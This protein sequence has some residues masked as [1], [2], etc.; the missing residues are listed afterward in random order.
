M[1]GT[2]YGTWARRKPVRS[3]PETHW[4]RCDGCEH[5][6]CIAQER[7]RLHPWRYYCDR[8]ARELD[9]AELFGITKKACPEHR[10]MRGRRFV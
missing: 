2:S 6:E 8:L 4:T 10:D 9:Y 3:T 5:F 7:S 1:S